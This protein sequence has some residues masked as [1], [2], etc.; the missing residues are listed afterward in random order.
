MA[1][2]HRAIRGGSGRSSVNLWNL[3]N[4]SRYLYGTCCVFVVLVELVHI[5]SS[6]ISEPTNAY[7]FDEYHKNTRSFLQVPCQVPRIPQI[8]ITLAPRLPSPTELTPKTRTPPI[9]ILRT[10]ASRGPPVCPGLPRN[11]FLAVVFRLPFLAF[12]GLRRRRRLRRKNYSGVCK[13][14]APVSVS[15]Q[16]P[17]SA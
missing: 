4:L 1:V 6:S 8:Y 3:W 14:N 15:D 9:A 2:C 16:P 5:W 13:I 12:L 7:K 10:P 17:C 11:S